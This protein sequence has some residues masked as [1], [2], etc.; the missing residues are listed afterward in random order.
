MIFCSRLKT[1]SFVRIDGPRKLAVKK[2]VLLFSGFPSRFSASFAR[3]AS[4]FLANFLRFLST[5]SPRSLVLAGFFPAAICRHEF[6]ACSGFPV[7]RAKKSRAEKRGRAKIPKKKPWKNQ[8]DAR[9]CF[10]PGVF[11]MLCSNGLA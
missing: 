2:K 4:I 8:T 3:L 5:I 1:S 7:W 10:R 9:F 6:H 11:S